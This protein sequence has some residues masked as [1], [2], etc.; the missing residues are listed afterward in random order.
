MPLCLH[1]TLW[2]C[3]LKSDQV[4]KVAIAAMLPSY[5][6]SGLFGDPLLL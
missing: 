1:G 4:V 2:R 6:G 5:L 3:N